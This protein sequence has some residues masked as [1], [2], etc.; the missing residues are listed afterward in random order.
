MDNR[1]NID[2][3]PNSMRLLPKCSMHIFSTAQDSSGFTTPNGMDNR[4]NIDPIPNSMRLLPK[5]SMHVNAGGAP[6]TWV[7]VGSSSNPGSMARE[8]VWVRVEED[9]SRNEELKRKAT[10][11]ECKRKKKKGGG[12]RT[13]D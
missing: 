8:P 12:R 9:D 13:W 6:T 7:S 4:I 1:I 2:P 11:M 3:I 10:A 5:C